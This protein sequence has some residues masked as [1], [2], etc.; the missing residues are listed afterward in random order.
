M[1]NSN[2]QPNP[3]VG[4]YDSAKAIPRSKQV[5]RINDDWAYLDP[6]SVSPYA[7]NDE[8][9]N[10]TYQTKGLQP[11]NL[12]EVRKGRVAA[13]DNLYNESTED[14]EES[15]NIF[16]LKQ[17]ARLAARKK[18]TA[19]ATKVALKSRVSAVNT[20]II[21]WGGSLWFSVQFPFSLLGV[22]MLGVMGLAN[23]II[24]ESGVIGGALTWLVKQLADGVK[25]VSGIDVNL[26]SMAEGLFFIPYVIVLAIGILTIL[27]A[28]LQYSLSFLHPLSGNKAGLKLGSL[29][30]ALIGYSTPV[31]NIF[32]W[33][34]I[35]MAVVWKYPR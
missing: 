14:E 33:A 19:L 22:A 6:K 32:P 16:R 11:Q 20:S 9:F 18:A 10:A 34:L 5:R 7:T 29:I 24:Q 3:N 27:I 23:S 35:W 4:R 1:A 28:Y 25:F 26:L 13:N 15:Q 8:R 21:S 30:F 31:L 17:L 2:A 12:N